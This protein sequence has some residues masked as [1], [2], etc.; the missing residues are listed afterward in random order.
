MNLLI[1]A[2]LFI[3]GLLFC[4]TY[5][6]HDLVEGFKNGGECPNLLIQ[7]GKELHLI[8]TNKARIPGVNP[9]KFK[10]DTIG[11]QA[12]FYETKL[13]QHKADLIASIN[14]AKNR[15]SEI[16]RIIFYFF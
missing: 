16:N 2:V 3:I 8:Y 11:W 4:C 5:S 6:H 12:R 14:T 13:S 7:K 10:N 1:I 9:I 15:H